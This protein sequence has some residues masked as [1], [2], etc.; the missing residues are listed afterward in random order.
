MVCVGV[1]LYQVSLDQGA[2]RLVGDWGFV[3]ARLTQALALGG[4]PLQEALLTMVTAQ[5]M[6][7]GWVH[8]IGNL[9]YLRVFGDNVEDKLGEA[10]YLVF[11]LAAGVVGLGAQYAFDPHSAVPIIGA[12]GAIAG[13]LGT[14]VILFPAARIV[15][16][17][18]VL[19]FL[20]FVEVP[21]ALF[22]GVW[23]LQQLLNGLLAF[24]G[25]ASSV[26]WFAHI[27]GFAFGLM[28]GIAVR[29]GR[30]LAR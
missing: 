11:Y 19:I 6:H 7:A 20:T 24:D 14:Y 5:F 25:V 28:V 16:L 10:A 30:R 2:A 22:V 27:G 17:F 26:A 3:P 21:A 13:T 29:I 9:V 4:V 15:T 8:I 12:S 1:F 23:G 18:P